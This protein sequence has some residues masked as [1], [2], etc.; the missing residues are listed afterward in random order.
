MDLQDQRLLLDYHYWA[1]DRVLDAVEP[2]KS[3]EFVRDLQGSFRSIRDTLAH[4][5]SAEFVWCSR[6]HGRSPT[7]HLAAED[8]ASVSAIRARWVEQEAE[9]RAFVDTIDD[10]GRVFEYEVFSG[11]RT[12]SVFSEMLQHVVNHASYHRGQVTL[13][14]RQL[15][16]A[17]PRSQDLITFY[18]ERDE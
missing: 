1:R 2:L 12:A 16:A 3:D 5:L 14:L 17:P 11:K 18:R 13:M 7:R 4:V 9:V 8:Y 10:V 6:W 15:Q